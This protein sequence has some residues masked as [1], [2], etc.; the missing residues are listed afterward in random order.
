[1]HHGPV[2]RP[3][4]HVR[5]HA[6]R[7]RRP[8]APIKQLDS[9]EGTRRRRLQTNCPDLP[10]AR[11]IDR[12]G[13]GREPQLG[14]SGQPQTVALS[15]YQA[16]D[17]GPLRRR[18]QLLTGND[19][20]KDQENTMS[21]RNTTLGG[22]G[23]AVAAAWPPFRHRAATP[24]IGA[25]NAAAGGARCDG[26]RRHRSDVDRLDRASLRLQLPGHSD[27]TRVLPPY[28]EPDLGVGD[29]AFPGL[30]VPENA[31]NSHH[32]LPGELL[33]AAHRS[34]LRPAASRATSV[35]ATSPRV[36]AS[37]VV[38]P[39]RAARRRQVHGAPRS[40][41]LRARERP[42]LLARSTSSSTS[43]WTRQTIQPD[44]GDASAPPFD[45]GSTLPRGTAI[46]PAID[47]TRST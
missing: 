23:A 16:P 39:V 3:E 7:C 27:S 29:A 25:N 26:G 17:L 12:P 21:K 9:L 33:P 36:L 19:P 41:R 40:D 42:A 43:C 4:L 20:E 32:R 18:A 35:A 10:Y 30:C 31:V 45:A 47:G 14:Q 34:G 1:M 6:P 22:I 11:T 38:V 44:P 8:S 13:A 37:T 28:P 15:A 5:L 46:S 2:G 24:I